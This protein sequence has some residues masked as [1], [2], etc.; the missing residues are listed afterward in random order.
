MFKVCKCCI[1]TENRIRRKDL[2]KFMLM[3]IHSVLKL[4]FSVKA[5]IQM[6]GGGELNKKEPKNFWPKKTDCFWKSYVV[7]C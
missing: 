6:I 4:E 3:G 7:C 5:G 2:R 1:R